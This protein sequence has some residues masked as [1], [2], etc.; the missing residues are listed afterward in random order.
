MKFSTKTRYA[1]RRTIELAITTKVT[2]QPA[3]LKELANKQN[4]SEKYSEQIF[5][6]LRRG[7]I[8][9]SV[10][11]A[12]GGYILT[13]APEDITIGEIIQCTEGDIAPVSCLE[14]GQDGCEFRDKCPTIKFWKKL[15]D[16]VKEL[17]NQVTLADLVNGC[18]IPDINI[19]PG[20]CSP[21]CA[22][23]PD[24]YI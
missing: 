23:L 20:L 17:L 22:D 16:T 10:R 11:G 14:N 21:K 9:K 6:L 5:G 7:S 2:S 3:S 19:E 13:R 24:Y 4:V 12:Q 15:N 18:P 8:V 1:W